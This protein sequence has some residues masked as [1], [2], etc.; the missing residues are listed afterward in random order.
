[1][2]EESNFNNIRENPKSAFVGKPDALERRGI[3]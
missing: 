1:V 2:I 3:A